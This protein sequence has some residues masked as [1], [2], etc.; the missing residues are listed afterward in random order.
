MKILDTRRL[1]L[2]CVALAGLAGN[3]QADTLTG[4]IAYYQTYTNTN[5]DHY[6]VRLGAYN[7]EIYGANAVLAREAFLRKLTVTVNFNP[8]FCMQPP[9]GSIT[10]VTI[11]SIDLP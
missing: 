1:G 2:A 9:C 8:T 4:K 10:A 6:T 7:L 5:G 3:A 11:Q